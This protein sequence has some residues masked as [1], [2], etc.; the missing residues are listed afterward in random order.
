MG[1]VKIVRY[2]DHFVAKDSSVIDEAYLSD[3][4]D[5]YIVFKSGRVAGYRSVGRWVFNNLTR[6]DS[7]GRYY[8]AYIKDN[9]DGL[10]GNVHFVAEGVAQEAARATAPAQETRARVEVPAS[11]SRFEVVYT[12]NG[13]DVVYPVSAV[14]EQDALR[15]AGEHVA[16]FVGLDFVMTKVIHYFD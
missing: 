15:S 10:D 11:L 6:S 16:K 4:G 2:V 7:V 14:D 5:V 1:E 12:L 9:F 13:N 8:N 3:S